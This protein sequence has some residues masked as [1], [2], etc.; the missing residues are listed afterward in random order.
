MVS[1]FLNFYSNTDST[2]TRYGAYRLLESKYINL[3]L[4]LII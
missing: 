1:L 3:K 2:I 4:V